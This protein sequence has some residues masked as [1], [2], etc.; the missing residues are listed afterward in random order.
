MTPPPEDK[1]PELKE[2]RDAFEAWWTR[3]D[4][5]T[6]R[7]LSV[8]RDLSGCYK[9]M[10]TS[11]AW[12]AFQAAWNTRPS[13]VQIGDHIVDPNKMVPGDTCSAHDVLDAPIAAGVVEVEG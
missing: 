6:T 1:M 8:E 10:S 5:E 9:L 2:C 12:V 4:D 3:H 7:D 11:S 13:P